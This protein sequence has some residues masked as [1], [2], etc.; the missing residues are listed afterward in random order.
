MPVVF[1]K[2]THERD[3]R[4]LLSR[5]EKKKT[6]NQNHADWRAVPAVCLH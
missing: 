5:I 1:Q 2:D 3:K 4:E 6:K